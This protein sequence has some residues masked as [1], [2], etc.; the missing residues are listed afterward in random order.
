MGSY[1]QE[2]ATASDGMLCVGGA[3]IGVVVF[4]DCR[5]G[6][7]CCKHSGGFKSGKTLCVGATGNQCSQ[8]SLAD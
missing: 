1:G 8:N 5:E 2:V 6:S 3:A 4:A 7:R